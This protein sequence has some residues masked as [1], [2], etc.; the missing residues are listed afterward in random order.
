[1]ES[2]SS[3]SDA[4][5]LVKNTSDI[6]ADIEADKYSDRDSA[7]VLYDEDKSVRQW[8]ELEIGEAVLLDECV[9][10]N[11]VCV[12]GRVCVCVCEWGMCCG[13]SVCVCEWCMC[14]GMRT[15]YLCEGCV[16]VCTCIVV[17]YIQCV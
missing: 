9:C 1:M 12:T 4:W 8:G 6:Q 2:D 16:H 10:V 13:T 17:V 15:V 7:P 5:D 14:C 3:S 11:G